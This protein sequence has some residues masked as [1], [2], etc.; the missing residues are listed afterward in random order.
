MDPKLIGLLAA[1]VI[2]IIIIVIFA[3][4]KKAEG[5]TCEP[6]SGQEILNAESYVTDSSGNCVVANCISG[7]NLTPDGYC[8]SENKD[9]SCQPASG[10]EIPNAE[11][12]ITDSSGNCVVANCISGY[13]LSDGQ[14]EEVKVGDTCEPAAG[15]EIPNA[16]TYSI[17]SNGN[18]V[19]ATCISGYNLT[20]GQCEEIVEPRAPLKYKNKYTIHGVGVAEGN[21]GKDAVEGENTTTEIRILT[22][23]APFENVENT[24]NDPDF[25]YL[26]KY[27]HKG[28]G[29]VEKIDENE[30]KKYFSDDLAQLIMNRY[31]DFSTYFGYR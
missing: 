4:G 1:V 26:Y 11:S 22:A 14:C 12:Y 6:E 3:S 16:S 13:N 24:A 20:D 25:L 8:I 7:Y 23:N 9:T 2:I 10:Q 18:C 19:V 30:W 27:P 29:K 21:V 15:Q 31:K 28:E 5:D 17:N